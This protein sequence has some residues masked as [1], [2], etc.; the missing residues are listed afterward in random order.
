MSASCSTLFSLT[1]LD[2]LVEGKDRLSEYLKISPDEA[3]CIMNS[4]LGKVYWQDLDYLPVFFIFSDRTLSFSLCIYS[5]II[6][7]QYEI[8][9]RM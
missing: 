9:L 3:K 7:K 5:Y 4:F 1:V 2:V 6:I 8:I